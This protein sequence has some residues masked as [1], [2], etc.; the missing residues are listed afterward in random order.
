MEGWNCLE[1]A[2][3][4]GEPM[5]VG[6][7]VAIDGFDGVMVSSCRLLLEERGTSLRSMSSRALFLLCF[8]MSE[9]YYYNCQLNDRQYAMMERQSKLKCN[10]ERDCQANRRKTI[11]LKGKS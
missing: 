11:M 4:A 10:V 6:E 1:S 3:G 7:L 8:S 9:Y 5:R 2:T